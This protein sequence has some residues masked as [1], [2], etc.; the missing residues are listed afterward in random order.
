MADAALEEVSVLSSIYCGDGEFQLIQ[1]S[2]Q[3]G[4]MVQINSTVGGE[5]RLD[6][7]LLFHLLPSYP[8]CPPA[9]SVSSTA[10]SRTQCHNIRQTLLDQAA[11]L[12]PEPMVHQLVEWLQCVEVTEKCGEEEEELKEIDR[13]EEWTAVLSLDHIRC[14]SRYIGLLERWS[15]TLQLSGSLLLGPSILVVLQGARPNIKEFCRLLK[16]V[17]VDVDSSGKKCKERMMKVLL[18]SP[19]SPSC[20]HSLQGFLVKNYISLPELAAAF[21]EINMTELYQQILPSLRD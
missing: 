13:E 19:L 4:L 1:Q 10:L 17:K 11:A 7:R 6:V 18:E 5:R 8:S 21:Q 15:Q 12:P 2:A 14:R 16:T 20:G 3:D 9:I